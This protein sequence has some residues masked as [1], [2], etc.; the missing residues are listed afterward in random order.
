LCPNLD[1]TLVRP[2]YVSCRNLRPFAPRRIF[3]TLSI[4]LQISIQ[5]AHSPRM[6]PP[7]R[8][9]RPMH[10]AV[11][12]PFHPAPEKRRTRALRFPCVQQ[13]VVIAS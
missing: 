11:C 12:F 5:P 8:M 3:T 1:L 2:C 13:I 7:F 4:A 9:M 10:A 6:L